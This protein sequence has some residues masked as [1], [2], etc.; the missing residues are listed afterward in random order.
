[1]SDRKSQNES[2]DIDNS[3]SELSISLSNKE[4]MQ[5]SLK[6]HKLDKSLDE[7]LEAILK[8]NIDN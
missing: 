4:L 5:L 1:L 6:A 8:E 7:T 3:K 2:N